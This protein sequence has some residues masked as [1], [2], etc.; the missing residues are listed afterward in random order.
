MFT[1]SLKH[2]KVER[3]RQLHVAT[4]GKK[5]AISRLTQ[6]TSAF[7][8][9]VCFQW[10]DAGSAAVQAIPHCHKPMACIA[11]GMS[12]NEDKST[13]PLYHGLLSPSWDQRVSLL[14]THTHNAWHSCSPSAA[15][16]QKGAPQHGGHGVERR[17]ENEESRACDARVR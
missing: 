8:S 12:A 7:L 1:A 11:L 13:P 3:E 17:E 2:G 16:K 6:T 14:S 9:S 15:R 10:K 4:F 5:T